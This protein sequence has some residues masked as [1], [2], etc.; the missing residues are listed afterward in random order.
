MSDPL[1]TSLKR[2]RD[3]EGDNDEG[4]DVFVLMAKSHSLDG[5]LLRGPE[6]C[7]LTLAVTMP[8]G[9]VQTFKCC[10]AL[11]ATSSRVLH[12]RL[13]G[14]MADTSLLDKPRNERILH[15]NGDHNHAHFAMLLEYMH[16]D[17]NFTA[18]LA[19][20]LYQLADFYEVFGL[21]DVCRQFWFDT[22]NPS[23]C[24]GMLQL[25]NSVN[26]TPLVDR[27][28]DV[29]ILAFDE[30]ARLDPSFG[31]LDAGVLCY[32]AGL[33]T[34]VCESEH[35]LVKAL[36]KWY[37]LGNTPETK[38]A[39]LVNM[40][41]GAVRWD[42][43]LDA[44]TEPNQGREASRIVN[45]MERR[46]E[47]LIVDVRVSTFRAYRCAGRSK[48]KA[49]GDRDTT[50]MQEKWSKAQVTW[51]LLERV[52]RACLDNV[53]VVSLNER[54]M[55]ISTTHP[56]PFLLNTNPRQYAWGILRVHNP[57]LPFPQ[58]YPTAGTDFYLRSSKGYVIG[59]SRLS[60]P[61][62]I[63]FVTVSS[64]HFCVTTKIVWGH[65][66]GSW[67]PL[68]GVGCWEDRE[69]STARLV[70]HI[71]DLSSNGTFLDDNRIEKGVD[72]PIRATSR[73]H[74]VVSSVHVAAIA[75]QAAAAAA[76][77][78]T[79]PPW[80]TFMRPSFYA[81]D[82][83]EAILADAKS[84][85]VNTDPN[86]LQGDAVAVADALVPPPTLQQGVHAL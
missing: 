47:S 65:D 39:A 49:S 80:F 6:L 74:L 76:A 43:V 77:A 86:Q 70:P 41:K 57:P 30:V 56:S 20:A 37:E 59:R 51:R 64:K 67:D 8:S 34:L 61:L 48:P 32:I 68:L 52:V 35:R 22:L 24:C 69:N 46:K 3:D 53:P 71:K 38:H 12:T 9:E 60:T 31:G 81:G 15:I 54:S 40:L 33:D 10:A 36:L 2:T 78:D 19:P 62:D 72:V 4:P 14:A 29:L 75:G 23:N 55:G 45:V 11:I 44:S 63:N 17:V 5:Q 13:H 42:R 28:Y 27:C 1:T 66:H 16:T 26:C 85:D 73:I 50:E 7:D 25:A 79:I 84:S 58:T 83:R 21:C 18:D 82:D